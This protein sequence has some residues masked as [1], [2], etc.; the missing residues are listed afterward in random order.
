MT[1]AAGRGG[2]FIVDAMPLLYRGYFAFLKNPRRTTA[3]VNTSPIFSFASTVL[4]IIEK[5]APTHMAVVFD[6]RTPTFRHK[7]YPQYKAQRD[8]L[9]EDIGAAIPQA[10]EFAK[11]MGIA[12]LR[13]DGFE[14]D[15]LMGS[16]AAAAT[17]EG[18]AAFLVT[19]DK[20]I[21]Q[22]VREGVF[23]YRLGG[24][25]PE[26]WGADEV[27]GHWGLSSP[28]QMIDY[29]AL[30]GDASDNIPGV[31]GVGEKTAQRLL[32]Q[33]G[34]V[35]EILAAAAGGEI[36]GKLGEKL[37]GAGEAA[38]MSRFLTEI[39]CDVP[40][41]AG[42]DTMRLGKPDGDAVAAF[43]GKYE[44]SGLAKRLGVAA[45]QEP[46]VGAAG[47]E[48]ACRRLADIPHDYRL[49][50]TNG[51][52][53]ELA[54]ELERS[55]IFAFDTEATSAD[56]GTAELAGLSFSTG[57]G[58][59]WYVPF[60][61][62]GAARPD[63]AAPAGAGELDLFGAAAGPAAGDS[64]E[65]SGELDL[66]GAGGATPAQSAAQGGGL[67]RGD[68]VRALAP[69]FGS[70]HEK[71]AHNSK[72]DR[73][74][75]ARFGMPVA[76]PCHDTMLMHFALDAASRHGL[77]FLAKSL[78]SYEKIPTSDIIGEGR[79]ADPSK[80]ATLPPE[81]ILDYAAEDAD[82]ALR[83]YFALLPK[84]AEAHLEAAIAESEEPLVDV[85]LDIE[86][87]GVK[88]DAMALHD[89]KGELTATIDALQAKVY[90]QAGEPF[91]LASPKQLGDV[92][93]GRLKI[94]ENPKKTASG[95]FAT[96]EEILQKYAPRNQIVRDILDWRAAEKLRSTYVDKLPSFVSPRD[97]LI[98]THL[99]QAFTETGRL[100]SS[101][102]NLQNIPV[103]SEMGKRIRAAFVARDGGHTLISADYSQIELRIMASL[104]GDESMLGAFRAGRDI[105][106]ETA[107]RVFGVPA[108]EV[109]PL[110]RSQ[111]KAINFGIIYGMSA[112]GLSQRLGIARQEAAGFIDEYFRHY[113]GV[114]RFMEDAVA[115]ARER[116]YAATVLGR[117]RSLPDIS[118]R[119]AATRQAAE[120]NAINTPVQGS[121]AD[122]IKLAMVK[123]W[124]AI[125][126]EGLATRLILQIHDEL[127][128]DAP[129]DEVAR[130]S[131]M[132][133]REMEGAFD[134]GIPLVVEIGT[135]RTWLEAH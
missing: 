106:A 9:P 99:S 117:R 54:G 76:Q 18:V 33:Y 110:Q 1:E 133:R 84:I 111:C 28:G 65:T 127:L 17:R 59:A 120:R 22:L 40:L 77:D 26:I 50:R 67:A 112:F 25:T 103:R 15:D 85:L 6:S 4:Q 29:L 20:D 91:N 79:D 104:S 13:V 45:A 39:R 86:D 49:V 48:T 109:T 8:K 11:A 43:C 134:F 23:L 80:M 44:L 55:A 57:A 32:A 118:S 58:R 60:P 74:L 37:A 105:H 98:H 69:V 72:Y 95:Q 126:A 115:K 64:A 132:V 12:A 7:A 53:L 35:E 119:N 94:D 101:D 71:T 56:A 131:E 107:S 34:G 82:F 100:A 3:G 89:F 41:P 113:P 130:V 88:I 70:P 87:A 90:D 122:L 16:L 68:I 52:L 81:K 61:A 102:P 27:M 97:G 5:N 92:L 24:Q 124:R 62:E 10:E 51:E 46:A 66:F 31:S 121:A 73:R 19:P 21:A 96:S 78:L 128:L 42:L 75:L 129:N 2:M 36:P 93:F 63:G 47:A 114:K 38:R 135:G 116:G 30:A 14:A 108:D 83:V 125:R 123:V